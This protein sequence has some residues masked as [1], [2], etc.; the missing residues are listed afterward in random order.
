MSDDSSDD[1]VPSI[2]FLVRRQ[3]QTYNENGALAISLKGM[4]TAESAPLPPDA[5]LSRQ[6]LT[7][8]ARLD[9]ELWGC[10]V[11]LNTG[12]VRKVETAT[13]WAQYFPLQ[14]Y[15]GPLLAKIDDP[16]ARI[17]FYRWIVYNRDIKEG[18]GEREISYF[19]LYEAFAAG[20]GDEVKKI[21]RLFPTSGFGYWGDLVAF[22]NWICENKVVDA[23]DEELKLWI[24][25]TLMFQ[26]LQDQ[27]L[28][29]QFNNVVASG[30]S[31]V[32]PS[33]S[34]VAKWLPTEGKAKDAFDLAKTLAT[35]MYPGKGSMAR[36]RKTCSM[37]RAYLQIVETKMSD[38]K[39]GEI[40]PAYVPAKAMKKYRK[41]F[42]N[43]KNKEEAGRLLL[44]Q[45]LADLLGGKSDKKIKTHGLQFYELVK[46]YVEGL[47]FDKVIECQAKTIIEDMA[48]LVQNG[49]FPLSVPLCD[50][51]GS[52][53]GTPL[54]VSI[55]LGILL[56][57]IMPAPWKGQVITFETKPRWISI[58]TRESIFNQVRVL[59]GSPWGG[60]TNFTD[61]VHLIMNRALMSKQAREILPEFMFCFTDMQFDQAA[62][63]KNRIVIDDLK[64]EFAEQGLVMPNLILWNLRTSE[65]TSFAADK[66]T[67]GVGIISGFSQVVFKAFMNGCNFERLTPISLMKDILHS[68]R[69]DVVESVIC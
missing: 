12:A 1:D 9:D 16:Y 67:P 4:T 40:E 17:E 24:A 52:M 23:Q 69:Y 10:I 38:N 27:R 55:A 53:S 56:A 45:K 32:K 54:I 63:D 7:E 47:P 50:V 58:P 51:S 22:Y 18:K 43:T 19:F 11:S 25:K 42:L 6:V 41:V 60:S 15:G 48:L 39:W 59:Q 57:N 49:S 65:T 20:Y 44:A 61:A 36:Y 34:L 31:P 30:H 68:K 64:K 37:L 21:L 62:N 26:T 35:L 28:L 3:T 46:P 8:K 14:F 66:N 29:V 13:R 33:I 2:P 5:S